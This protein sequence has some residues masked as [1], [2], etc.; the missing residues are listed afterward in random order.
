[1]EHNGF[2]GNYETLELVAHDGTIIRA[3]VS[4]EIKNPQFCL[5]LVHGA[6]YSGACWNPFLYLLQNSDLKI[7]TITIHLRGHGV[8][9]GSCAQ[10]SLSNLLSDAL[11]FQEH[12]NH[13]PTLLIGHSLGGAIVAHLSHKWDNCIGVVMLDITEESALLSVNSM[14]SLLQSRP[15]SF[16]SLEEAAKWNFKVANPSIHQIETMYYQV[17][18]A[19]DDLFHWKIPLI[20]SK[21]FW[22]EWFIGM[23]K[24]FLSS[25]LPLKILILAGSNEQLDR[26]LMMG[27]MRGQFQLVILPKSSH[28]I[29]LDE[30]EKLSEIISSNL[31]RILVI[32]IKNQ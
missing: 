26:E 1:M 32:L 22:R 7:L 12:S 3:Q 27:Q 24:A 15:K 29:M 19:K 8:S 23:N 2:I 18:K 11:L 31:R 6:G 4:T 5:I 14:D 9:D 16:L 10:M 17:E 30:P 20:D 25:T 28:A 13:L 21:P